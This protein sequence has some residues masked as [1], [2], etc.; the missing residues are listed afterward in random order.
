M[1]KIFIT[2][3]FYYLESRGIEPERHGQVAPQISLASPGSRLQF[4][5]SEIGGVYFPSAVPHILSSEQSIHTFIMHPTY[6]GARLLSAQIRK[7][8][9]FEPPDA[10]LRSLDTLRFLPTESERLK[11]Q[12]DKLVAQLAGEIS[13]VPQFDPRVAEAIEYAHS[14]KTKKVAVHELAEKLALSESRFLHLF[15]EQ[16]HMTW[17]KY[18]MWHRAVEGALQVATG[19]SITE[20]AHATGFTDSAH[21]AKVFKQIFGLTLTEALGGS[22]APILVVGS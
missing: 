9:S 21:F 2:E 7:T 20:A 6:Q 1:L 5:G 10:V 12:L 17:R 19:A 11:E 15:K 4:E 14:L 18:L 8:Q 22:P 3:H 13:T 16:M